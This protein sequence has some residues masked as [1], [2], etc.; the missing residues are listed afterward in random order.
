LAIIC[1]IVNCAGSNHALTHVRN[2]PMNFVKFHGF[3]NDYIVFEAGQVTGVADLGQFARRVCD[4]HFGAGADG[5]TVVDRSQI[6]DADFDV[7]IFNPDGSE[8]GLSGN[9]TRCT[10]S[11]LHYR[12]LW[13]ED[14]LRLSTRTGIKNY[15]LR[16]TISPGH[17][18][19]EAELGQPRLDNAS[20]PMLTA[21]LRATVINYPVLVEGVAWPVTALQMGNP[22]CCV[23]VE[24][25]DTLDWRNLGRALEV[26]PNFPERTNVIFVRIQD[27]ANLELRIW[28]RGAG[29]TLSSGT[30][31]CAAAVAG[32]IT[33]R[34]DRQVS[35]HTPGGRVEVCWREDNEIVMTGRADVVYSGE[36]LAD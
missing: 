11:Y 35:V 33:G 34:T 32:V 6:T 22:N 29:E 10:A 36:W 13:A 23:F 17:Y 20:I 25:F 28:E 9:G 2:F 8:A 26:H 21:G 24:D 5:I 27:R 7:R 19:F 18:W 16:E 12:G 1:F 3:G 4:R 30:C 15:R 31:S 14:N